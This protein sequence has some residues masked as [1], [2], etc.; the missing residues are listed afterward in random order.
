MCRLF[1]FRSVI[2]S[3]VH[4]SLISADNA[5]AVQSERHPDGWGVAYYVAQYPHL[6]KSASTA[7]DDALFQRVSGIVSSE[8]VVAHVRKATQG[9]LTPLNSHPFQFGRWVMAHNGDIPAFPRVSA[10]LRDEIPPVLRRFILGDT[11]SEVIFY[12]FLKYLAGEVDVHRPGTP[13]ETAR[14]ALDNTVALVRNIADNP[15]NRSLLTFIVTN[16]D[17]MLA[18]H[19]GKDLF[20]S[21][22]KRRCPDREVCASLAPV[23]EA[24]TTTGY[25]NHFLVSS[26][27]LLGENVWIPLQPNETVAVDNHMRFFRY[28]DYGKQTAAATG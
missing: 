28:G 27:P 8:T 19:G 20:F 5:L 25:V 3:Q 26:E 2:Q 11:D 6:I 16:G 18:H 22:Y 12:L 14:R 21:T 13:L 1:G 10:R 15:E 17:I 24:E 7:L 9:E 23:C 4:R